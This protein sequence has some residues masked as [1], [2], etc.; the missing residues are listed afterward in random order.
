[1]NVERRHRFEIR[2]LGGLPHLEQL[3]RVGDEVGV[4][5]LSKVA[6]L[7]VEGRPVSQIVAPVPPRVEDDRIDR[8]AREL[9]VGRIA[10]Q[11]VGP[12]RAGTFEG[13]RY[14]PVPPRDRR[15]SRL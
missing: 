12:Q 1:M 9:R 6:A 15:A 3:S 13:K 2:R 4:L 8:A 14:S 10:E 5:R 7:G 11:S